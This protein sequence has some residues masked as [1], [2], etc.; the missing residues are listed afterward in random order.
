[1]APV[2]KVNALPVTRTYIS[3]PDSTVKAPPSESPP[4]PNQGSCL[5]RFAIADVAARA[6]PAVVNI[7]V[8]FGKF[9]LSS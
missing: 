7:K 2:V 6:A 8:S 5:S 9:F 1:M 3:Q 4:T